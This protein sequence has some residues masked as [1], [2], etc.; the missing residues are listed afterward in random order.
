MIKMCC[1]GVLIIATLVVAFACAEPCAELAEVA[2][3]E[4]G[5]REASCRSLRQASE[6]PLVGDRSACQAAKRFVDQLHKGR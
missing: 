3:T 5:E 1:N 2:C 6:Q 4:G